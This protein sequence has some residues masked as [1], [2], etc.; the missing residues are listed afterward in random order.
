MRERALLITIL[1]HFPFD[2]ADVSEGISGYSKNPLPISGEE[3]L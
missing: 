3:A 2:P 1:K